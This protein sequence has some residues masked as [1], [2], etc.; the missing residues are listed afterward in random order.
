MIYAQGPKFGVPMIYVIYSLFL[1][2][3]AYALFLAKLKKENLVDTY[4][5]LFSLLLL[6]AAI[7]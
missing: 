4:I 7:V 1:A 6:S 2:T 3:A 5:I